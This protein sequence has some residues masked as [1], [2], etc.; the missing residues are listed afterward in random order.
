MTRHVRG[1]GLLVLLGASA[2]SSSSKNTKST[3]SD[4]GTDGHAAAAGFKLTWSLVNASPAPA[5][6]AGAADAGPR[7]LPGVEGV[8]ICVKD[9][10]EI[11]CA[12]SAADGSF[13][14]DGL[15]PLTNLILTIDKDGF[16][17]ESKTIQTASTDMN[18][19]N[20]ILMFETS[21]AAVAGGVTQDP[22]KGA[23]SLF[24]I[25]PVPG[26]TDQTAFQ[27]EP[28]V[29]VSLSPKSGD[30][31]HFSNRKG[32]FDPSATTTLDGLA[33]YYN[34]DPGDY[35]L[36]FTDAQLDCAPISIGLSGWGIPDPP[37]SVKFTVL[38]GYVTEEV[39]VFCTP[40]SVIVG[41]DGG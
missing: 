26:S 37:S 7:K 28:G 1:I 4:A 19:G 12:T 29:S 27:T 22:T 34:V 6:D 40:K 35:T 20:G 14:L 8:K 36:T 11:A 25:G 13:E 31:P 10:P 18:V 33:F 38:A 3:S 39:G 15:P 23:V 30:G 5:G 41:G 32:K 2:C 9:H 21:K 24:A 17:K 16:V